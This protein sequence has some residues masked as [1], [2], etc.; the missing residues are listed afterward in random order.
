[1]PEYFCVKTPVFPFNRFKG[2]DTLLGPEMKS[3]GEVMGV[4]RN[5]GAAFAKGLLGAGHDLQQEGKVFV[6][7]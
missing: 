6:E 4:D 1:M 7:V 5:F 3:T 2:V